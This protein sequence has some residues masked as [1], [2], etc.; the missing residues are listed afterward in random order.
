MDKQA[1][2]KQ[3]E[4]ENTPNYV[5]YTQALEGI[6]GSLDLIA[7]EISNTDNGSY[8]NEIKGSIDNLVTQTFE[9]NKTMVGI[10]ETL[11]WM[12]RK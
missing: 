11:R 3:I 9:L 7:G 4:L 8:F 10:A 12:Q 2:A 5:L 6:E 1:L